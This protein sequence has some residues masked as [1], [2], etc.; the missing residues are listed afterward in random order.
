MK[1]NTG[2]PNPP[3]NKLSLG[4]ALLLMMATCTAYALLIPKNVLTN[5]PGVAVWVGYIESIFPAIGGFARFSPIPEVVKF[6]YVTLWAIFPCLLIW[7]LM[8]VQ[9]QN[10]N[11]HFQKQ[12]VESFGDRIR[13][14]L[15]ILAMIF[16][17]AL[18]FNLMLFHIPINLALPP[19]ITGGR[20]NSL[21]LG[22]TNNPISIGIL[23]AIIFASLC[24]F[25]SIVKI[26]FIYLIKGN[27]NA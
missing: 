18:I 3:Q 16:G 10:H 6:Y 8:N 20:A 11:P 12:R 25:I 1:M 23:S 13:V 2:L 9:L 17:A 21:I 26:A 27:K 7:F 24:I 5:N 22:L 19:S 15:A 14:L 4:K